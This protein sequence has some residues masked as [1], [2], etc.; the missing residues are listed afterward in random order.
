M[1]CRREGEWIKRNQ[2]ALQV[3]CVGFK[4]KRLKQNIHRYKFGVQAI[5][6]KGVRKRER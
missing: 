6:V 3:E 5:R 1:R 4:G 2:E